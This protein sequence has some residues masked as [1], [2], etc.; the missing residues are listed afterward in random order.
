MNYLDIVLGIILLIGLWK[1]FSNGL[2]KELA[3]LVAIVAAIYGATHFSNYAAEIIT[4]NINLDAKYVQL[5]A[6]AVTFFIII[7]GISL[8]GKVLT[9]IADTAALGFLNKLAGGIFGAVKLAF[10]VSAIWMFIK[11][12]NNGL[13]I[14]K[15]QTAESSILFDKVEA[16]APAILPKLMEKFDE[17][18]PEEEDAPIYPSP[19]NTQ[20]T[21]DAPQSI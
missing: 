7:L 19:T 12:I 5:L 17:M 21:I 9:K 10:I 2:F 13:Q 1:G 3:S 20:P 6:F 15:K 11:P 8:L 4:K 18:K 16:V 14:I